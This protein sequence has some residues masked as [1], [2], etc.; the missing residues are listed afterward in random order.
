M[1][2]KKNAKKSTK[3][4]ILTLKNCPV[5]TQP[6]PNQIKVGKDSYGK[7]ISHSVK[8]KVKNEAIGEKSALKA[9]CAIGALKV[10]KIAIG[11]RS[12]LAN[13]P[14]IEI[15]NKVTPAPAP[16]MIALAIATKY[17]LTPITVATAPIVKKAAIKKPIP[18]STFFSVSAVATLI[19]GNSEKIAKRIKP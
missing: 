17:W 12:K 19:P 18:Q 2:I 13:V 3:R 14:A 5:V 7:T 11:V 8:I 15:K 9:S 6:N 4:K 16:P 10:V 1:Q